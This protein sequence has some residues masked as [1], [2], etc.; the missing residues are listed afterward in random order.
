MALGLPIVVHWTVPCGG[1][2]TVI[3]DGVNGLLVP[4]K[5]EGRDGGGDPPSDRKSELAE[6]PGSKARDIRKLPTARRFLN[7]GRI[8]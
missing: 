6:R 5:D 8:I 1:P 7:S 3:Q 4:I 2:R